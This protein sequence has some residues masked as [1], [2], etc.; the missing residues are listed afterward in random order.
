M[1]ALD[2]QIGEAGYLIR[3]AGGAFF[4][5]GIKKHGLDSSALVGKK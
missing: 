3:S 4:C 1:A 5:S 2:F